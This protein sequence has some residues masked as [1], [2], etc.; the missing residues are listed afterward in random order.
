MLLKRMQHIYLCHYVAQVSYF[1][2]S[3][4]QISGSNVLGSENMQGKVWEG[5]QWIWHI[6]SVWSRKRTNRQKF[7]HP[8]L[9]TS[10]AG[11]HAV[12]DMAPSYWANFVPTLPPFSAKVAG[13]NS[14]LPVQRVPNQ[15]AMLWLFCLM[16]PKSWSGPWPM[17]ASPTHLLD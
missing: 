5:L 9:S 11:C 14:N 8:V 4:S 12:R 10:R 3:N 17:V 1:P 13:E 7:F 15:V 6:L 2:V 16:G